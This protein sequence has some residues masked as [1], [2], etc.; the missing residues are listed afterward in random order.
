MSSVTRRL[1]VYANKCNFLQHHSLGV[2]QHTT[3][4][5]ETLEVVLYLAQSSNGPGKNSSYRF[6]NFMSAE[7]GDSN[8]VLMN[9]DSDYS[10]F[11]QLVNA[12]S[13]IYNHNSV[14]IT[15]ITTVICTETV[16]CYGLLAMMQW[17]HYTAMT[18]LWP[19]ATARD[20]FTSRLWWTSCKRASSNHAC[21]WSYDNSLISLVL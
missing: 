15:L 5:L 1:P 6:C 14:T 10:S 4:E 13:I 3:S 7:S 21:S 20:S 9:G 19:L 16:L 8:P 2:T 17:H 12:C 18:S 11:T